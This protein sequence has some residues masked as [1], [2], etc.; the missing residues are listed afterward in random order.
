MRNEK[1]KARQRLECTKLG[2]ARLQNVA[3]RDASLEYNPIRIGTTGTTELGRNQSSTALWKQATHK[4]DRD[5]MG[6]GT[7][8]KHGGLGEQRIQNH[9]RHHP[10]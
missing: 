1:Y 7:K 3:E 8:D 4:R 5:T 6:E 10:Q 9:Q 2:E